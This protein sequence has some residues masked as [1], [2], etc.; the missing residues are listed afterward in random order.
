MTELP[1][2]LVSGTVIER[3]DW[4]HQLFSI[5]V[6][7]PVSSYLAGQ[8]TKLGLE[9][10]QGELVRRA[11]SMVNAPSHTKGHQHLEF[12][13]VKD[14]D[15]QLSPRLHQLQQGDEVFV[16][17]DPSGFMTLE[18]IPPTA[19]DLWMLSTGTAIGPFLSL[20]E[21]LQQQE[22]PLPF[23]HLILVHA[24]RTQADLTYQERIQTFIQHFQG[25]LHYVPIISRESV[26]GALRG[27]IPSLLLGGDLEQA[28]TVTINKERS[29]F[30]LCGN[31]EM[32]R[33]TSAALNQLGLEKHLRRKPGQ[34]SSE[35][36]W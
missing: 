5:E 19:K 31:P 28:T 30:Y 17:Q 15:G 24:V 27:R 23:K 10:E 36:Y 9:N 29:F 4:N 25:T 26:T 2:G 8:F 6:K 21:Q 1:H 20:L 18:E 34:F 22:T 14:S 32:V 3:T 7:A 35:N 12:L 16:G 13:I 33:D 11:Y